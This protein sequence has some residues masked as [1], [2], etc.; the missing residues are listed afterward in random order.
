MNNVVPVIPFGIAT[1]SSNNT[2][3]AF[4]CN[5]LKPTTAT[6]PVS[7]GVALALYSSIFVYKL[8]KFNIPAVILWPAFGNG[9][10]SA[11]V[12]NSPTAGIV[13]FV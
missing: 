3:V 13:L 6:V 12:I 11:V 4:F 1:A 2:L 9:P 7:S 5:T 8:P 10:Y